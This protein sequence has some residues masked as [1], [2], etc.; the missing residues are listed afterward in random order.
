MKARS[1]SEGQELEVSSPRPAAP[2]MT[3][4]VQRRS[5]AVTG[6][7]ACIWADA[8]CNWL[9]TE[10]RFCGAAVAHHCKLQSAKL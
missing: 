8:G 10:S 2:G 9:Q 1:S 7:G 4:P 5:P 3:Q 6:S